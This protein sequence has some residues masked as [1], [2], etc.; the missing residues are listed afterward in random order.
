MR[1]SESDMDRIRSVSNVAGSGVASVSR[2]EMRG[3]GTSVSC[4][5]FIPTV[6]QVAID[7]PEMPLRRVGRVLRA[8]Y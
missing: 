7:A 6:S 1:A 3:F 8:V 4:M 5:A 2:V